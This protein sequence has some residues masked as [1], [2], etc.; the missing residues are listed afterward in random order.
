MGPPAFIIRQRNPLYLLK[1]LKKLQIR[2]RGLDQKYFLHRIGFYCSSFVHL[3]I[4]ALPSSE[5]SSCISYTIALLH[6]ANSTLSS[7]RLKLNAATHHLHP[8]SGHIS[9]ECLSIVAVQKI[10]IAPLD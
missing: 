4:S 8:G 6:N 5:P 1:D 3:V 9:P 2:G 10:S 7:L